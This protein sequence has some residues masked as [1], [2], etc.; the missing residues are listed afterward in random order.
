MMSSRNSGWRSRKTSNALN[1]RRVFLERSVRSTRTTRCWRRRR[2]IGPSSSAT[3]AR[4][5]QLLEHRGVDR[6]GV[7]AHP[8]LAALP[9]HL[10]A[11][12][13]DPQVEQVLAAQQEVARVAAGVEGDHVVGQQPAQDALADVRRQDAPVV[14]LAPR[15]VDEV[16]Q[17]GVRVGRADRLGGRVE[18]VVV[19]H[20]D[21]VGVLVELPVDGVGER[22]VGGEVAV[23]PGVQLLPP[24]VRRVA[25]VPQVVL[26]EPE[27]RVGDDVVVAGC[28]S[29]GRSPRSGRA[30]RCRG[31]AA[32]SCPRPPPRRPPRRSS[33]MAADTH[34][35]GVC[36]VEAEERG[37]QAA[38]AARVLQLA[39]LAVPEG[40]G[41]AVGHQDEGC[42]ASAHDRAPRRSG[43]VRG[44]SAA[45]SLYCSQPDRPAAPRRPSPRGR[46]PSRAIIT[47]PS[48]TEPMAIDTTLRPADRPRGPPRVLN[49]R[50]YRTSWL[51]AGVALVVAL[52]TLQTPD[53]G[54]EPS[55]PSTID[56]QDTLQLSQQLAAI[57][58][59]RPPGSAHDLAA[60]RFVQGQL[61]QV[62][63]APRRRPDRVQVQ[64]FQA[65]AQRRAGEPAERLPRRA[66]VADG[67]VPGGGSW[68]WRRATRRPAC[69]PAP[70]PP[71]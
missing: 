19:E 28:R 44:S 31:P 16:V 48:V 21:P 22:L 62:P 67:R 13:V 35:A 11:L 6:D 32:R 12:V 30:C 56:G 24:H 46:T 60:A 50:L 59:E 45:K 33:E 26:D 29:R 4:A 69:R 57:A 2:R 68:S 5:R 34:S 7:R 52:L 42:G 15:D 18:V 23:L 20:H 10:A 40:H 41:S 9:A 70:A 1:P 27:H 47:L 49:L 25:Q 8:H 58:P 55:L 3:S 61:A 63:G 51:V 53:A 71:P 43:R 64:D 17:E 36:S 37:H 54:P 65:R 38:A 39:V 66:R 14:G